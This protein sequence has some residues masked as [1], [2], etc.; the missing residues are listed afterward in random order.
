MVELLR[1]NASTI[2]YRRGEVTLPFVTH[3][4]MQSFCAKNVHSYFHSCIHV[5]PPHC[6]TKRNSISL[7][8]FLWVYW[9]FVLIELGDPLAVSSRCNLDFQASEHIHFRDCC[10][11]CQLY[12]FSAFVTVHFVLMAKLSFY[13]TII[14]VFWSCERCHHLRATFAEIISWSSNDFDDLYVIFSPP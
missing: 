14:S 8:F 10:G 11:H 7:L 9:L 2:H 13:N 5:M 1:E 6:A 3:I 4:N 12:A